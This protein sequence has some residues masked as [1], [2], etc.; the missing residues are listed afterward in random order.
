MDKSKTS[1]K[2]GD[3]KNIKRIKWGKTSSKTR[4]GDIRR[5]EDFHLPP[6]NKYF[7]FIFRTLLDNESLVVEHS[8][9]YI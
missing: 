7:C 9:K 4:N 8:K 5:L 6:N 3:L 1:E 2:E